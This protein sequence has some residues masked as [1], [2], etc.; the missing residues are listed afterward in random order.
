MSLSAGMV[1]MCLTWTVP[2]AGLMTQRTL[3]KLKMQELTQK[4][5]S[6][7]CMPRY[8]RS[9]PCFAH[10]ILRYHSIRMLQNTPDAEGILSHMQHY[11]AGR[12]SPSRRMTGLLQIS[13]NRAH[14]QSTA[15]EEA[16]MTI[17]ALPEL[18]QMMTDIQAALAEPESS[19]GPED[20]TMEA[21]RCSR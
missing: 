18:V 12:C 13:K 14:K 17:D 7:S 19:A 10:L 16:Q 4:A 21:G 8:I 20:G 6:L 5:P 3:M 2:P 11:C 1:L 9:C 15:Q